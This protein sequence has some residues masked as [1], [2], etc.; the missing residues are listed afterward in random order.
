MRPC[1]CESCV[2]GRG[3]CYP[4]EAEGPFGRFLCLIYEN[5]C[6]PDPCYEPRWLPLADAAFFVDAVRPVTQQRVRFNAGR[7]LMFPDRSEY[8]WARADG[9]GRGPRP[10]NG[11]KGEAAVN[12]NELSI[13]TEAATATGGLFVEMPYRAVYP[14]QYNFGA[15]FGDM[16]M[17]LKSLFFDSELVQVA[18]QFRTYMPIGRTNKGL[19]T[20]HVSLEPSVLISVKLTPDAYL[21]T[22]VSEWIPLGGDSDYQGSV[23][24][25]HGSLNQTLYRPLPTTPIVGTLEFNGWSF[26]HGKYTDPATGTPIKSSGTT[27]ASLGGGVRLFVCD[28]FDAGLGAAFAVTH[29]H[30]AAQLYTAELRWRY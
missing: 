12:Y 14:E 30:W 7:N 19:G 22:Q 28:R 9:K 13:Y 20:G 6:C 21:Q 25:Y 27:C 11:A 3:P 1:G 16:N 10:P 23:L 26:Q 4:C 5:V 24:H 29:T 2:P 18:T 15:G 8:F 17:G